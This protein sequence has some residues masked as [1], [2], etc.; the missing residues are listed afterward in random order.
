MSLYTWALTADHAVDLPEDGDMVVFI[1]TNTSE[2][3]TLTLPDCSE[4]DDLR[5]TFFNNSGNASNFLVAPFDTQSIVNVSG[6]LT[7]ANG[8]SARLI[9]YQGQW[10]QI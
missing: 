3:I 5:Y 9:S 10:Y 4:N 8:E 2:D 1:D 7:L 6:S